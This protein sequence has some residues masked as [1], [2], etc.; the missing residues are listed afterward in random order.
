LDPTVDTLE[1]PLTDDDV[2]AVVISESTISEE[3][4]AEEQG[5][6]SKNQIVVLANNLVTE[7]YN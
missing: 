1:R 3:R 4:P 5:I 2:A 6:H 7:K